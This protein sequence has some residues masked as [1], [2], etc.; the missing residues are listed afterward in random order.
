M[1]ALY[2]LLTVQMIM[3]IL[4][5]QVCCLQE[6]QQAI[7]CL[8]AHLVVCGVDGDE[9]SLHTL[10]VDAPPHASKHTSMGRALDRCGRCYMRSCRTYGTASGR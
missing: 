7:L 10:N 1:D 9:L 5:Q 2:C 4:A 3:L 6:Y 8:L